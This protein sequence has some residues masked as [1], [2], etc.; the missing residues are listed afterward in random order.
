VPAVR[1]TWRRE[2]LRSPSDVPFSPEGAVDKTM[3]RL[4]GE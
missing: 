1:N 4:K 2:F 3:D